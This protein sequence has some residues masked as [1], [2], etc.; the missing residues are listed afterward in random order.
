MTGA[1]ADTSR[2]APLA[3]AL[4]ILLGFAASVLTAWV[5]TRY[6][7]LDEL[8]RALW[9]PDWADP[10]QVLV[11]DSLM[12]RFL[13]ALLCGAALGGAG[14]VIQ[15]VLH[16]PLAEPATLGISGG[17]YLALTVAALWAPGLL[18][19]QESIAFAGAGLAMLAVFLIARTHNF[20]P[21]AMILAGLLINLVCGSA[22][23]T[24]AQLEDQTALSLFI[25]GSG[26][27]TQRDWTTVA[28]IGWQLPVIAALLLP[29]LRPLTVLALDD[30]SARALGLPLATVRAL[31]LAIATLMAAVVTSAVGV[32]GFVGLIAPAVVRA[33]G[34]RRWPARLAWSAALGA[35]L[36]WLT[37]GAVQSLS[38]VA[39]DIPAGAATALV[40]A[41]LLLLL[42]PRV[43]AASGSVVPDE[44]SGARRPLM[45]IVAC[46]MALLFGGLLVL[47]LACGQ[48]ANGWLISDWHHL[49]PLLIWRL[50]RM[51]AAAG[52]G[53]LTAVAGVIV[54]RVM[55][56]PMASPEILGVS[57]GAAF[58]VIAVTVCGIELDRPGQVAAASLGAGAVLLVSLALTH[59]SRFAPDR[60]LLVGI[61][62]ATLLSAS[63][64][65]LL[66]SGEPHT[67]Q[68]LRWLTGSTYL[69]Q[70]RDAVVVLAAAFGIAVLTGLCARWLAILPLSES[71]ASALGVNLTVSRLI[72][73]LTAAVATAASTVFIGPLSFVGL[74]APHMA[75]ML[76]YVRPRLHVFASALFGAVI[77]IVADWAGRN[78]LFPRELPAGLIAALVGAPYFLALMYKRAS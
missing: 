20:S 63:V 72:L 47:L 39:D 50:P 64:S 43:R 31:A 14:A 3:G 67:F 54:Q 51:A 35:V 33:A 52:A 70:E 40:G 32:I 75:R 28:R 55:A 48:D 71:M 74:M 15:Q 5:W 9:R 65:W 11:H 13:V 34:A 78:V 46:G 68:I 45:P 58:A 2:S 60:L 7:P 62:L 53:A 42:L 76:G 16:N 24:V 29:L 19:F 8:A 18:V 6:L 77:M 61:A 38:G 66:A 26:S 49:E 22:A 69:V 41:P 59:R 37:D 44:M 17:A 23:A 25:W 21:I 57:S 36:L 56:N 1:A 4:T 10:V 27:L 73:L 12:P 30:G